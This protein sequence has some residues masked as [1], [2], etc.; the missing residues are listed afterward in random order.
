VL[1]VISVTIGAGRS[2]EAHFDS[3]DGQPT[4]T[5]HLTIT[6]EGRRRELESSFTGRVGPLEITNGPITKLSPAEM[7][8]VTKRMRA[9]GYLGGGNNP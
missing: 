3:L 1:P 2:F 9:L 6:A 8:E 7:S 5:P 4:L